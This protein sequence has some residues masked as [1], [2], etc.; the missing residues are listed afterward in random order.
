MRKLVLAMLTPTLAACVS[1]QPAPYSQ[2]PTAP[3]QA[4]GDMAALR[5]NLTGSPA[6]TPASEAILRKLGVRCLVSSPDALRARY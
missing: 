6:A 3:Y 1:P 4:C 5:A 2:E